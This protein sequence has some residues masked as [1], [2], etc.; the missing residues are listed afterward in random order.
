[1]PAKTSRASRPSGKKTS[2]GSV[3][4]RLDDFVESQMKKLKV[5]GAA[6]GVLK[7]GRRY[8]KGY[9]ITNVDHPLPVDENTLF[10]IG[11][12]TKTYTAT[13][14]MMLVEQGKL[15]LDRPVRSYLKDFKLKNQEAAK[16][17]T[18]RHLLTHMGGW[19]GD[20][21][22]ETGRGDDALTKIVTDMSKIPQLTPLGQTWSYNNSGF[23]VAGRILERVSG[24]PYETL[25]KELIFDP[26]KMEKTYFFA[27]EVML[28]GFAVGHI[29]TKKR[30]TMVA[31]PWQLPRSAHPAGGIT[32][33]VIDQLEYANFHLSE[34]K[35]PDGK[36][37]LKKTSIR[38]MQKEQAP[39]GSLATS[40][41]LSWLLRDVDGVRLVAHGGTTNG[42]L[43]AFLMVPEREF[44]VTV[45]TNANVGGRLHGRVVRWAL[46]NYLGVVDPMPSRMKLDRDRLDEYTGTY[47]LNQVNVEVGLENGGLVLKLAPTSPLA[48]D[49]SQPDLP[50]PYPIAFYDEDRIFV[51]KGPA[52]RL[53]GEFLRNSKGQIE[54]LRFGG[55]IAS[56]AKPAAKKKKAGGRSK[57]S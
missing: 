45:L 4:R 29:V 48:E 42:Q 3:D 32:S 27:E 46:E 20:Y 18:L 57:K 40:V 38:E 12:T 10:Q 51:T 5:P 26:L 16:K 21:F 23:Y 53:R 14:A 31:K 37:L 22:N 55:R 56:P 35:D 13:A 34:G 1:M 6:V 30:G 33:N 54:W 50:D 8:T 52:E 41:G 15:D 11:S 44:A 39:A 28:H 49:G 17:V 2:S 36:R 7:S 19:L 9:G 47:E 43:S 24:K 25:L